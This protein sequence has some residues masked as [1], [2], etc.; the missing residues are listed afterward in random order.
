MSKKGLFVILGL[1]VLI[2]VILLFSFGK[3]SLFTNDKAL[4]EFEKGN[5]EYAKTSSDNI[6]F[7]IDQLTAAVLE[8]DFSLVNQIIDSDL[9]DING[10]DSQGQYPIEV[11]LVMG[12]CDMAKVLLTAG[13]DPYVTTS[14]GI[15]VYDMVM[16]GDNEYLKEV[17]REYSQ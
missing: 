5:R 8:N 15:S 7:T 17:F 4:E 3:G 16:E 14:S 12:N 2:S 13:A 10:K 9:V 11:V 1:I 6:D